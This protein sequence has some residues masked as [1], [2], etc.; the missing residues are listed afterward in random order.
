[1]N[2]HIYRR[3]EIAFWDFTIQTLTQNTRV[4]RLVQQ[5]ARAYL[6]SG[7]KTVLPYLAVSAAAGLICGSILFFITALVW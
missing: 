6:Q 7:I 1:M 5:V 4:R 2:A 3:M